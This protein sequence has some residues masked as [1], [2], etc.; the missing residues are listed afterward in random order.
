MNYKNGFAELGGDDF[1][2][3]V[4]IA[5][6]DENVQAQYKALFEQSKD[7]FMR[8]LNYNIV[9]ADLFEKYIYPLMNYLSLSGEEPIL[10][11][12]DTDKISWAIF[13]L[14]LNSYKKI[15][16]NEDNHDE[17]GTIIAKYKH[18]YLVFPKIKNKETSFAI[19]ISISK[20]RSVGNMPDVGRPYVLQL[21]PCN[22]HKPLN[23]L[24]K[25]I[26]KYC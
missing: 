19:G 3:A 1:E 6:Q 22:S 8:M 9:E 13:N 2:L 21:L 5:S 16:E 23:L 25:N 26:F 20:D 17:D 11:V 15:V 24:M 7:K 4:S 18:V 14:G 10:L 12:Y